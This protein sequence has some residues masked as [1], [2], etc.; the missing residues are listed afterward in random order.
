MMSA[1]VQSNIPRYFLYTTLKGLGFTPFITIWV[2]YLQQRGYS[3]TEATLIDVA[4]FAATT[5]CEVPTGLVADRF[6]RKTSLVIGLTILCA[7]MLAWISAPTLPLIMLAHVGLGVGFTFL[8]GADEALLYETLQAAGRQAEYTRFAGHAGAPMLGATA[9]GSVASGVLASLDLPMPFFAACFCMLAALAVVLTFKEPQRMPAAGGQERISYGA[10]LRESVRTLR[11]RPALHTAMWYLSI[12][13]LAA[14]VM[15]TFF[16]QPQSVALGVPVAGVGVV[17]MCVQITNI[18][19]AA[20]S[21]QIAARIGRE[22][23]LYG[24]PV[25]IVASL[26]LLAA[27]QTM[28]ALVFI[29]LISA[30]TATLQPVLM[31]RIQHDVGD[32]IRA[33]ILSI[34]SLLF[35]L[36]LAMGEPLLGFT[37]D[38]AG[39]PAAYLGLAGALTVLVVL[40]F[41][42]A[43]LGAAPSE[44]PA[45]PTPAVFAPRDAT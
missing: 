36:L 6:G 27:L 44:P 24:A 18:G 9:V 43:R 25:V 38:R 17:M 4:F 29:A 2:I 21:G 20:W 37:A 10:G 11:T 16:L 1:T 13:P 19:G 32:D 12:V 30:I 40:L 33:T 41:S 15:E 31:G 42:I 22:R 26:V 14:V 35:T 7:S 28:P 39:L 5:V 34:Q 23:L 45:L 8:S 3:L